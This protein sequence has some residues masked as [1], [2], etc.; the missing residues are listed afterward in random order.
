ME[1]AGRRALRFAA[2]FHDIGG[3]EVR[4]GMDF[5]ADVRRWCAT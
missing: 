4:E 2:I 5:L 3:I 1:S